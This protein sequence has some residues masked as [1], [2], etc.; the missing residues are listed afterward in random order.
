MIGTTTLCLM[1]GHHLRLWININPALGHRQH[2]TLTQY[3]FNVGPLFATTG[4]TLGKHWVNVGL[5]CL[6]CRIDNG[7][8]VYDTC[9]RRWPNI[10]S[11]LTIYLEC[12]F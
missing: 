9:L 11:I 6:R 4:P 3:W 8:L 1:L 10:K 2:D 7:G 12:I 5:S